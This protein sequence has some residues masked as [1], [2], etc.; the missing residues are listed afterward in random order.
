MYF[1]QTRQKA[2]SPESRIK[3]NKN[4]CH[5]IRKNGPGGL[6]SEEVTSSS[7]VS[8]CSRKVSKINA[9]RVFLCSEIMADYAPFFRNG[10]NLGKIVLIFLSGSGWGVKKEPFRALMF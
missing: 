2:E 10:E 3:S 1:P 5:E 4:E 6:G 7:L 9:F 8:S